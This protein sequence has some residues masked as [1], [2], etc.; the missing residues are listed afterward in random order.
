MG[1]LP[2]PVAMIAVV[3]A[4]GIAPFAAL[5][6]T[7]YTKLVVVFGLL[8]SALGIQQ[9]PPNI[10]LNGIAL[11]LTVFIMAPVGMDMVDNLRGRNFNLSSQMS[12][13]D[14]IAILD[15]AQ[16][17]VKK[18]LET[19]TLESERNF[20]VKS[21]TSIWPKERAAGLKNDDLTVLVP[22]FTLTELI[23]AF[24]VGFVLYIIFVVVD[25]VVAN[26]LLALGMQM[27]APTTISVPFKLLLFVMLDGWS[28]LVHGLVLSYR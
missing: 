11:I 5:M 21:A 19:H 10:V 8:R 12:V 23:K 17:P 4:L 25:L 13:D 1:N 16:P 15:A 24:Q 26:L 3:A 7:S 27:I 9:V 2:N 20:F 14:V 28:V 18:F 6:V 22:S